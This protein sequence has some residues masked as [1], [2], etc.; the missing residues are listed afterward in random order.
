MNRNLRCRRY[1]ICIRSPRNS[2]EGWLRQ[3]ITMCWMSV[4]GHQSACRSKCETQNCQDTT[5]KISWPVCIG[6][7]KQTQSVLRRLKVTVQQGHMGC[8]CRGTPGV[9]ASRW[10]LGCHWWGFRNLL[11]GRCWGNA[12]LAKGRVRGDT[13][14]WSA[15]QPIGTY[16]SCMILTQHGDCQRWPL[17][18]DGQ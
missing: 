15:V 4:P 9:G 18:G 13:P 16:W 12:G 5:G 1:Q 10:R 14:R 17:R 7:E 2:E 6:C 3:P 8:R 11:L